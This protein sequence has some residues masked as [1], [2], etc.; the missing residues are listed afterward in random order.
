MDK[1][2]ITIFQGSV[3]T[4]TV[5]GGLT[6]HHP[7]ANFLMCI[8]DKIYENWLRVDKL[9]QWKPCA[10]FLAHSVHYVN[11]GIIIKSR[12]TSR[13][14]PTFSTRSRLWLP[15]IAF[16]RGMKVAYL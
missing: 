5:L 9:L 12:K 2:V 3:V 13:R 4:K 11:K 14:R 10:V 7:V 6:M 16:T 15:Q 8:C 1:I